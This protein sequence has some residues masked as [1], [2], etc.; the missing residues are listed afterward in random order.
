MLCD[1]ELDRLD[2]THSAYLISTNAVSF[3]KK[4]SRESLF[5]LE[6]G[7]AF[8]YFRVTPNGVG[9]PA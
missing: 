7:R 4:E 6:K 2:R 8:G 3:K 5:A 1:E 9:R